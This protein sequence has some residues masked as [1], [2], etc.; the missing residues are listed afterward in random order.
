[1]ATV[2]RFE[3]P[4]TQEMPAFT[5]YAS[6]RPPATAPTVAVEHYNEARTL[7]ALAPVAQLV[8]GTKQI[9][10]DPFEFAA[11]ELSIGIKQLTQ[12]L[13]AT[14]NAGTRSRAQKALS[15]FKVASVWLTKARA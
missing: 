13:E 11:A 9:R 6:P 8:R 2:Y 4:A 14:T 3:F 15:T 7:Q 12:A 5:T 1:M 10:V